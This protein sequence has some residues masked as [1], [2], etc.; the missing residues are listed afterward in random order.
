M[1][2]QECSRKGCNS[3][4][5]RHLG[6]CIGDD[7]F[8]LDDGAIRRHHESPKTN[9]HLFPSHDMVMFQCRNGAIRTQELACAKLSRGKEYGADG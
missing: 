6:T 8:G 7:D 1:G 9:R 4:V 5:N 2:L 3:P